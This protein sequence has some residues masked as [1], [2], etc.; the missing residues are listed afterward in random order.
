MRKQML[1][2]LELALMYERIRKTKKKNKKKR[3]NSN[4]FLDK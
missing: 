3:D 2:W 1:K 4:N